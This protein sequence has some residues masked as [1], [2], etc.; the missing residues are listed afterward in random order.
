GIRDVHVTGVQTCAL[1]IFDPRGPGGGRDVVVVGLEEGGEVASV[2]LVDQL[3]LRGLERDIDVDVAE[4]LLLPG[5]RL[6]ARVRVVRQ[7]RSE[8]RRVGKEG[9]SW[10]QRR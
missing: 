1:P 4:R 7:Q 10:W 6:E 2:E 9:K 3:L 8:E 5:R